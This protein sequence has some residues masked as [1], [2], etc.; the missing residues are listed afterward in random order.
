MM[1]ANAWTHKDQYRDHTLTTH[2]RSHKVCCPNG[3]SSKTSFAN[4]TSRF[5][6]PWYLRLHLKGNAM[7]PPAP[8]C[9][10]AMKSRSLSRLLRCALPLFTFAWFF[11][12]SASE[13]GLARVEPDAGN[14]DT[15]AGA[16]TG[17]TT[18]SGSS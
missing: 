18:D 17:T 12:C 16:D 14:P 8:H 11:G 5:E 1:R 6:D 15:G 7:T 4:R 2:T 3:S 10:Y 9:V 13:G